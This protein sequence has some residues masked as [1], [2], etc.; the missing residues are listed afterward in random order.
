MKILLIVDDWEALDRYEVELGPRFEA[1]PVFF[2][3]DGISTARLE[4]P[5]CMLIDLTLEDM[6]GSDLEKEFRSDASF[7]GVRIALVAEVSSVSAHP[8]TRV[9]ARPFSYGEVSRFLEGK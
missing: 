6:D 2:G 4:R 1:V 9:F 5:E 3:Q 7:D 8:S